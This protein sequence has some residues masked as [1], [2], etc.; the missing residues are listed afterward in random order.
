L[1]PTTEN[2]RRQLLPGVESSSSLLLEDA[3]K[4]FISARELP[5]Y[6]MMSFQLGWVDENGDTS[7]IPTRPRVHGQFALS[8]ADAITGAETDSVSTVVPYAVSLEL[9]HNFTLIHED[10]ED[11]NT[12]HNGRPSVWW[13]WGPA[14]AINAGDGMHAM[15]RIALFDLTTTG[16]PTERVAESVRA[17]DRATV[18]LCEG[19]YSD[20][21]MQEQIALTVNKY[22]DM[23]KARSGA[24]FGASAQI[25]AH[26]TDNPE[27]AEPLFKF[28]Q[29]A[30]TA[31][32]AAADYTLFWGGENLDPVQH[33]RLL[34]KKKNLPVAY[35][36][37]TASP[38]LK[39]RLGDIYVQRVIDPMKIAEITSI[40]EEAGSREYTLESV[41]RLVNEAEQSLEGIGLSG[42]AMDKLG[43][44]A[45]S[46]AG[47]A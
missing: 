41:E 37:E 28:A 8:V 27:L 5:L 23:V 12:E 26:A 21:T 30:G 17:L 20:I 22:L 45:R 39:R 38:T 42:D 19:E 7:T 25:A 10:V 2:L 13:T 46:L 24:L 9:L 29:L 3:I 34:T 1:I 11:G 15:A 44:T 4:A 31:R 40:L 14:Q 33:G 16:E 43:R 18:L 47:Y 35:A 36:I 6:R 32:Q